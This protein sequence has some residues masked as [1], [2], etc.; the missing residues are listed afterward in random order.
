MSGKEPRKWARGWIA[1][2]VDLV[3]KVRD[4]TAPTIELIDSDDPAWGWTGPSGESQRP[5]RRLIALVVC[6][7]VGG[8]VILRMMSSPVERPE[9][10]HLTFTAGPNVAIL[11]G[12]SGTSLLYVNTGG[13][14]TL[15]DLGTGDR[16]EIRI[17]PDT[18]QLLFMVERGRVV[19]G[20][21]GDDI[22]DVV[23]GDR[24]FSILAYRTTYNPTGE[25]GQASEAAMAVIPMCSDFGCSIMGVGPIPGRN[26]D[27]LRR[28]SE[29]TDAAIASLFDSSIW[30]RDGDWLVAP[31]DAG[32][33]LRLPAPADYS[34]IYL[35]D[36]P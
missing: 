29:R 13:H 35:I 7:L 5:N 22:S 26:G 18:A 10:T 32:F 4:R 16:S 19:T 27:V 1:G 21:P 12:G 34:P 20:D 24:A 6:L 15:V 28:F 14:P 25:T 23:A 3:A 11:P 33:E 8:L 9:Q 17:A 31:P 36:Q 30:A 2:I